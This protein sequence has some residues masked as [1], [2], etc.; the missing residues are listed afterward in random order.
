MTQHHKDIK[1]TI[2]R[3]IAVSFV[4][5]TAALLGVIIY[6][7]IG[8]AVIS[9][10]PI[11]RATMVELAIPIR[12]GVPGTPGESVLAGAIESVDIE[13][14]ETVFASAAREIPAKARGTIALINTSGRPQP[15]V[16][17][18]R[19]LTPENILFRI[20][21]NVSVPARGRV[22]V[23]AVADMPGKEGEIAPT[24]F[25]IPG[26]PPSR[27][28]E[29]YA[30]SAETMTGG[31]TNEVAITDADVAEA[32]KKIEEKLRIEAIKKLD[33][34][35]GVGAFQPYS[36]ALSDTK[37]TREDFTSAEDA[38]PQVGVVVRVKARATAARFDEQQLFDILRNAI[39]RA[40]PQFHAV[41]QLDYSTLTVTA[42]E[43]NP[44]GSGVVR[45]AITVW[46]ILD[47]ETPSLS[48][49]RFTSVTADDIRAALAELTDI[50][51]VSIRL[52]PFWARHSPQ[53]KE[54]IEVRV[55]EPKL[56]EM[57][58]K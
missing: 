11:P 43:H 6:F 23:E 4:M 35:A 16:A 31:T 44:D 27:Q 24:T 36:L 18:T 29:V 21:K 55:E 25:T 17:T 48:P 56:I 34:S 19:L 39:A 58:T 26:L 37:E 38:T 46:S 49:E 5:L 22:S 28:R 47:A 57:P 50:K 52:F 51:E 53:F 33:A 12:P 9:I 3:R 42:T 32:K 30:E 15:L 45:A 2:Y 10:T 40:I 13:M 7:S 8:K 54:N 41:H 20:Q 14:S 1:F